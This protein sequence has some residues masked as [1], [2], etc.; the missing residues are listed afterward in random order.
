M[1]VKSPVESNSEWD[2]LK[3]VQ[4]IAAEL[5]FLPAEQS[6]CPPIRQ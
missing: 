3:L 2:M 6:E 1:Q 4:T 5:A